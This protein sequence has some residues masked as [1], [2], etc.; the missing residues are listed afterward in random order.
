MPHRQMIEQNLE[1]AETHVGWCGVVRPATLAYPDRRS[2]TNM[3]GWMTDF[4]LL[5]WSVLA[6]LRLR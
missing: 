4:T 1:Q 3:V 6:R 5:P 2:C